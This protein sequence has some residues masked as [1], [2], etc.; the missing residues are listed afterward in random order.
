MRTR[1]LTAVFAAAAVFA[2]VSL[3]AQQ[4]GTYRVPK[5]PW[6]EPDLQGIYNGNDL[7]GIPFQR[8][9]S[10]GTRTVLNDDEFRQRVAQRDQQVANDNSDEF[11]LDRAEEFEKRFGTV[12]GAVS[13]PPHWLERSRNV[14]RVASYLIDPPNGRMPAMTAEAQK[15]QQE[16][17]AVAQERRRLLNGIE[18]NWTTDRSNYDRCIS[19]GLQGS[20]TPKIYNS[21]NRIVQGPGWLAF[22]NEM[23]HETRVIPTDGRKNVGAGIKSWMGNS[24]G[25]WEG[26]TLVV[27][28]R[29]LNA[30]SL[31][32]NAVLSDVGVITERFTLADAN[33]LDYRMTVNDPKNWVA[34]WTMRMPIP[35]EDDY[36]FYEYGC[37]EGNYAM[38]NLLSGSRAEEKRRAEAAARGEGVPQAQPA[39]G[40]GRGGRGGGRGAGGGRGGNQ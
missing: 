20:T 25:R 4:G 10:L 38:I 24:V 30:Q 16:R 28:T 3:V 15:A 36:G 37:H 18:A 21:G 12:G 31:I 8:A 2:S 34:P 6:G 1:M 26:D 19:L 17:N 40:G 7:Q 5:T 23:I 22:S 13:P 32:Q 9:E 27:E 39:G 35:R 33:T 11:E 14:S 29:G